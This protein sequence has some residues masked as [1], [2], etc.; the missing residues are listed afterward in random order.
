MT[1]MNLNGPGSGPGGGRAS[2]VARRGFASL[3]PE[4]R[5]EIAQQGGRAAHQQ[6]VAHTWDQAGAQAAGRKAGA[7]KREKAQ[8]RR[9]AAAGL[10]TEG[11]PE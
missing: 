11:T 8:A 5:R 7:A 10:G 4:R 6:G 2:G 9:R 1:T 3:S